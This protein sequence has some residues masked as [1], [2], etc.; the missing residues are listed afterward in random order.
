MNG[1]YAM[2]IILF[3]LECLFVLLFA[4]LIRH[5]YHFEL[6]KDFY[7]NFL[8]EKLNIDSF[9]SLVVYMLIAVLASTAIAFLLLCISNNCCHPKANLF[10]VTNDG[11]AIDSSKQTDNE[12]QDEHATSSDQ[13]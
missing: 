2:S 6:Y 7:C 13:V 4:F 12:N 5:F 9:D 10:P 3:I 11:G 8:P 1:L